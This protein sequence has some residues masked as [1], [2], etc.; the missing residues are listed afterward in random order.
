MQ[1]Y[2]ASREEEEGCS[3][4]TCF[5]EQVQVYYQAFCFAC[6]SEIQ[7]GMWLLVG[8]MRLWLSVFIPEVN[9]KTRTQMYLIY[10]GKQTQEA[11]G[12]WGNE[13]EKGKWPI[14]YKLPSKLLIVGNQDQMPL[15]NA[16]SLC[17]RN[18]QKDETGSHISTPVSDLLR[19][20]FRILFCQT[21]LA[22]SVCGQSRIRGQGTSFAEQMQ[23]LETEVLRQFEYLKIVI[24]DG[25][26]YSADISREGKIGGWSAISP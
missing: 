19:L 11:P 24:P 1:R 14:K 17:E 6:A 21:I 8:Y 23:T 26:G 10:F 2:C 13:I 22:C 20:T 3:Q 5:R 15:G 25:Y 16:R 12:K 18:N 9:P 4:N 7:V